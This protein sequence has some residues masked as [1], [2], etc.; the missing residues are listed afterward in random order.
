MATLESNLLHG[1]IA[2]AIYDRRSGALPGY[3]KDELFRV[4]AAIL[5]IYQQLVT[6]KK[7]PVWA[8]KD[9]TTY[10]TLY[11]IMAQTGYNRNLVLQY[12]ATVEELVKEGKINA[13]HYAPNIAKETTTT[14]PV[15]SPITGGAQKI[16][17]SV[18]KTL[19]LAIFAGITYIAI[20]GIMLIP[21]KRFSR[22]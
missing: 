20:K 15:F 2:K 6:S 14:N 13:I 21:K 19:K 4:S 12:L 22:A 17:D 3:D 10:T 18:N 7:Y 16:A 1:T 9:G 8:L 5:P 11:E